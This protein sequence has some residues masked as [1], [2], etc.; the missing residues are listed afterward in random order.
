MT[1][2][3]CGD[4]LD[5]GYI[6]CVMIDAILIRSDTDFLT[7]YQ[8]TTSTPP[9]VFQILPSYGRKLHDSPQKEVS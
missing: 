1:V 3:P 7:A 6:K 4:G 8:R 2:A 9:L 5:C